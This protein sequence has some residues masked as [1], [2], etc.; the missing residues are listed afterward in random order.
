MMQ[1]AGTAH[2][3]HISV[4][5][6][7]VCAEISALHAWC[8]PFEAASWIVFDSSDVIIRMPF[9]D[10]GMGGDVVEEL[11]WGGEATSGANVEISLLHACGVSRRAAGCDSSER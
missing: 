3:Q 4:V 1:L 6:H 11:A 7:L 2:R 8:V 9:G 10:A 5:V